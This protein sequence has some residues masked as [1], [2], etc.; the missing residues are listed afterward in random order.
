M[1]EKLHGNVHDDVAQSLHN[2]AAMYNAQKM[3]EKSVDCIKRALK[4]R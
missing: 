1:Q 2:L 3:Y 4:I